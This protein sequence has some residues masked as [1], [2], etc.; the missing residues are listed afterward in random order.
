M[1]PLTK[2]LL[3]DILEADK[4]KIT[5]IYGGGFKPPTKGHFDVVAKAAEQNP[6]IDEF[7]IYVG[8]GVRDGIAQAESI[9]IWE[10][11]K[12][13]LP[14]K[15]RIEPVK[16]PVGDI[17]RYAKEHPEE[18]VLWVIGARENNPEDFADIAS[19]TRTL[20]KYPNLELRLIQTSGGVSG[21]ATRKAVRDNNKEQ[22]YN[23]IPDIEEKDQVWDIVSPIVTEG[24]LDKTKELISNFQLAYKNQKGDFEGFKD[25]F[26][27][28]ILKQELTPE[29]KEKLN[30][31]VI[32][33]F[34]MSTIPILGISG[35]TLL[36]T[37]TNFLSK[38]KFSTFPSKFKD[39]LLSINEVGE[40]NLEPYKWEEVDSNGRFTSIEFLTPS[41]TKYYVDL[42]YAE[43]DD[44]ED[45]DMAMEAMSV[46]FLAKPK[47]A[48]GSSS[49]IVVN[50]GE[51]YTVM[52]TI[53]DIIK[54]YLRK[55]RGDIK[56]IL[57]SPSKKGNEEF[58]SQRDNLYKAFISKAFPGIEFK[59]HEQGNYTIAYLPGNA[60]V[61]EADPKKGTGKKPKGSGRRLY[62]DEDPSDTVKVKF[63][64]KEDIVDTLNKESFKSK[65]HARQS[66]VINL[67]HQRVRAA[68]G[69][70]KDPEVKSRLKR[71]LDYIEK[72][73]E[74]SKK[75]T[76]RLRKLKEEITRSDLNQIERIADEWFEDYGIDVTFTHHF[77]D[78]V[79]DPRNGK[80]ISPEELEDIFTQSA[81][82]YGVKLSQLPDNFEAVLLKLR[83]DINVPF[84]LNYDEKNDEIDLV[85]KTIMRKKDFKTSNPKLTLEKITNTEIICDNCGW[86][87][88]IK[89]GGDDLY[90][91]HKCGH[92]NSPKQLNENSIPSIDIK[93]KIDQIN[94]YMIDKGHNMQP[95]PSV[96]FIEDDQENAENFLGKTAYYDPNNKKIVLYTFGRHPKDIC[97]SYTHEMI[98]HIQ[99]LENRLGNVTTTN[100]LE[101]D[102][103]NKLEQEA[104]LKGTMTFRNWTDSL[105]EKKNKDPFGINAYALELARDLEES[106]NKEGNVNKIWKTNQKSLPL[107]TLE[108][109]YKLK[110]VMKEEETPQ[111]YEIYCDMDG[112]L[113][114]FDKGYKN[115][116]GQETHHVDLQGKDEFWGTFRQSLEDKKM[117]EKDY[118]ANLEW[119]PDGKELWDH[120]QSMKPTLLSAP[121]RDPQ[122]RWGKRIW[123][124]K[125]IPG[126]P[127]ILAAASAKK[128]YANKNSILIDDRISNVNEWNAAGGI[129]ILHT[130]TSSTIE[131]LSKYGL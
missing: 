43:I 93:D 90:I 55:S 21:T 128:N 86:T 89:D 25:L 101:D 73:K 127:L 10:I 28:Y 34:K 29:E 111:Q 108:S 12:K 66:Q 7:I 131:K 35:T 46:E 26:K 129:G 50:K 125:N 15:V 116:T 2:F 30:R 113:V 69:K 54:H 85:A 14:L 82:K 65:S 109:K 97:R 91:C 64:T 24:I 20:D 115:L 47:G 130:S 1:N 76:E 51:M 61:T 56:A 77:L 60:M 95:L 104:N 8:G 23:L 122:S 74:M 70:A 103:I 112:V 124:K 98:H 27:K 13:Y 49:K 42:D 99:N 58:G 121:S 5:A 72:R 9:M 100:T 119:M 6:E 120:I 68:Y 17:L 44:P 110:Q 16:T 102:N 88:K 52:S 45:E 92:D 71:A 126:T 48:E 33:I 63:K 107:P 39:K 94:K 78:R 62:T 36:G 79:N 118:W 114:D 32:D 80:P 22:F 81:E 87:W 53:A 106:L 84:A 40:A 57:Y 59:K 3:E 31:N 96:E 105:Q 123:V 37:L 41:E 4:K 117:Q 83:N 19:R 18:E 38:G 11:Y 67:I 75:K